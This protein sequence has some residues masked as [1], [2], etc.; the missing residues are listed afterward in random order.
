MKL[1]SAL[2]PWI[3]RKAPKPPF[4][5]ISSIDLDSDVGCG[6]ILDDWV[7]LH[8]AHTVK[9]QSLQSSWR[10][11]REYVTKA[12]EV[13]GADKPLPIDREEQEM[14]L[15]RC[16]PLP[17][18]SYPLYFITTKTDEGPETIVY[19]GKTSSRSKRFSGG[20]TAISKLHHPKFSSAEKRLYL[21]CVTFM[22]KATEYVP[23]EMIQPLAAVENLLANLEMQLIYHFQPEL[24]TSG[25]RRRLSKVEQLIHLQG[26][27]SCN[28]DH[29]LYPGETYPFDTT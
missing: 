27:D 17:L 6:A 21:G 9:A 7:P 20:H 26:L 29:F 14:I 28:K 4:R 23:L 3:E 1:F 25:K 10:E 18:Q 5:N 22:D 15:G 16:G 13:I 24:N 2:S 12:C 8:V 19:I 11:V